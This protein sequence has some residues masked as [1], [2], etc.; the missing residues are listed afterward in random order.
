[1]LP[2]SAACDLFCYELAPLLFNVSL[3]PD[4]LKAMDPFLR[5]LGWGFLGGGLGPPGV[6]KTVRAMLGRQDLDA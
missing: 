5:A 2:T 3:S 1:M 6:A 4:G